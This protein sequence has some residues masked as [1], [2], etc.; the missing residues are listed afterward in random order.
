MFPLSFLYREY[1]SSWDLFDQHLYPGGAWRI[2]MLRGLLGDEAFWKGVRSYVRDYHTSLVETVDFQRA[3]ERPTGRN[4]TK[5][6]DQ[7][8]YLG[9][10]F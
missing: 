6:F 7:V 9:T 10:C 4:L 8:M 5:F 3:L 2:H 1:N